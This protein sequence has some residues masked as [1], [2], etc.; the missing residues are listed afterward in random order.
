MPSANQ[1]F[2]ER[3]AREIRQRTN[4]RVRNVTIEFRDP[5]IVV[6]GQHRTNYHVKQLVAV[7]RLAQFLPDRWAVCKTPSRSI[8]DLPS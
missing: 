4:D 3:L 1:V 2:A 8:S 5:R 6:R 7:G